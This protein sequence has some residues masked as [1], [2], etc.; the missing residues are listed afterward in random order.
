MSLVWVWSAPIWF[1]SVSASWVLALQSGRDTYPA[2]IYMGT[3]GLSS[4]KYFTHW[5]ISPDGLRCKWV[6][7]C[8]SR[9]PME[10]GESWPCFIDQGERKH[11]TVTI[12]ILQAKK[13]NP[14]YPQ[15][16][17]TKLKSAPVWIRPELSQMLYLSHGD[18]LKIQMRPA[19]CSHEQD[20]M[21]AEA[22]PHNWLNCTDQ[23]GYTHLGDSPDAGL[24]ARLCTWPDLKHPFQTLEI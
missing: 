8:C 21:R 3:W 17:V 16:K 15:F 23:W 12:F 2:S 6:S 5:T 20:R 7:L 1:V 24:A 9:M 11:K 18:V 19:V 22:Q 13:Q 10:M 14:L 4:G